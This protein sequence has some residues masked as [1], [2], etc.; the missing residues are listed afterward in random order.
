[1]GNYINHRLTARA[2]RQFRR[3]LSGKTDIVPLDNGD[4]SRGAKWK[5]KKMTY[6]ANFAMLSHDAQEELTGAFY[7]ANAMLYYFRFRDPGDYKVTNSPLTT[8]EG[9]AT[10]VKLTKR[11]FFGPVG[12]DRELQGVTKCTV[13]DENGDEFPGTFDN[14]FGLFTPSAPWGAGPYTWSG[15]F[16]VWVRF[17]SDDFDMTL[18]TLDIATA[19]VE[20]KEGRVRD[21]A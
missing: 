13:Y 3:V 7:A 9:T 5:F 20:L 6:S 1:M 16:D 14:V 10:A 18:Q 15:A 8:V 2:S 12:V 4:E 11:Y 19:D 17:A 21:A